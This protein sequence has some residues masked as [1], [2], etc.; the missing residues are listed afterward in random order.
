[1]L[2]LGYTCDRLAACVGTALTGSAIIGSTSLRHQS[3][4]LGEDA[5][6]EG[7]ASIATLDHIV[8]RQK[9]LHTQVALESAS[10]LETRLSLI[11][12]GERVAGATDTLVELSTHHV[13]AGNITQVKRLGDVA[14]A[15]L[16]GRAVV[17]AP[18]TQ[19]LDGLIDLRLC[20]GLGQI[21]VS[22]LVI[23]LVQSV[24]LGQHARVRLPAVVA[25]VDHLDEGVALRGRLVLAVT[26]WRMEQTVEL[27]GRRHD[28]ILVLLNVLVIEF[29]REVWHLGRWVDHLVLRLA[30]ANRFLGLGG[31]RLLG[32]RREAVIHLLDLDDVFVDGG[33][34]L[35]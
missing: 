24:L 5:M 34:L 15:D 1:M 6:H 21:L 18:M 13:D 22:R 4:L 31:F 26:E 2:A 23:T 16:G 11:D 20:R 14:S 35:H 17:S 29:V 9:M 10:H 33:S 25:S 28:V 3:T 19:L 12:K 7:P 32:C 30:Q 8:A 27:F